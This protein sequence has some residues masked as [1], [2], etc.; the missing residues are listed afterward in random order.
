MSIDSSTADWPSTHDAVDRHLLAGAHDDD[1]A[2]HDLFD[3]HVE[4]AAV[5]D[6]AGGLR[7]QAQQLRDRA[8]A[9]PLAR[10]SSQRPKR[11]SAMMITADSK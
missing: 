1:V 9:R 7:P 6:D 10:A 11:I 8:E 4:L 5:A 2:G 3:R